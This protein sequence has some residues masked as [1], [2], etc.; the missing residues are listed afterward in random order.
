MGNGQSATSKKKTRRRS[1]LKSGIGEDKPKGISVHWLKHGLLGE[2]ESMGYSPSSSVYQIED[3]SSDTHG[4]IRSK[5]ANVM[6]P[7]DGRLGA[8]YVDCLEGNDNVGPSTHM[9][10]YSWSYKVDDIAHTLDDYCKSNK[11]NPK[12][13]YVWICCLCNNQH[14]VA[15]SKKKGEDGVSFEEFRDIFQ[16]RVT[17]IG[18]VLTMM[19]PWSS[20]AYL[21]SK[22]DGLLLLLRKTSLYQ[23]FPLFNPKLHRREFGASLSFTLPT[24]EIHVKCLLSCQ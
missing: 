15:E 10:S 11:L 4:V 24:R 21:V 16:S 5:G 23:P 3:L 12:R 22:D 2:I 14:R 6:C 19:S 9:L 18:H 13:V 20:P 1:S 8:S 17:G 7:R